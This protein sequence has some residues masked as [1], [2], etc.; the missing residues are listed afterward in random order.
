MRFDTAVYQDYSIPPYYD[1]MIG[2][3]IVHAKTREETIC[4][5]QAALCELVI[6][7]IEHTRDLQ[8]ELVS[9]GCIP[10]R[11]LYERIIFANRR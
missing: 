10:G 2:K 5:M 11:K 1:S 8:I 4:K 6:E 9:E 7:G 3:L